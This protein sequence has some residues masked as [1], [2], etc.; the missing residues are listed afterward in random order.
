MNDDITDFKD[1]INASSTP[2]TITDGICHVRQASCLFIEAF[3]N[4]NYELEFFNSY[5][6][7]FE[8]LK[9]GNVI[10]FVHIKPNFSRAFNEYFRPGDEM[11]NP[12]GTIAKNAEFLIDR[13][14]ALHAGHLQGN[15]MHSAYLFLRRLL[16]SCGRSSSFL[17]DPLVLMEPIYGKTKSF[18]S[19]L[20]LSHTLIVT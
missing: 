20:E 6:N 12:E 10:V 8:R 13:T 4:G 3:Q 16:E 19:P 11:D 7:A 5:D 9:R 17:N 15:V 1:C 14:Q 18:S 2:T